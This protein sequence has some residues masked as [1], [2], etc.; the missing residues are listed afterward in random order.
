MTS[1][2]R[3]VRRATAAFIAIACAVGLVVALGT[4]WIA[5]VIVR[6]DVAADT[7]ETAVFVHRGLV[8]ALTSEPGRPA[9]EHFPDV[10]LPQVEAGTLLRVK[11][12]ERVA[13]DLLRLVYSDLPELIGQ[14]KSLGDSRAEVFETGE[15]LV[16][17]VPDDDAHRTE[18]TPDAEL[19]E[20]FTAFSSPERDYLLESY[21][22]TATGEKVARL[23]S[24]LLPVVL[25]GTLLFAL[26]MLPLAATLARRL[27]RA[28]RE[29][30]QL[31]DRAARERESE[32]MR[33][34]QQLHDGVV[35]DLAGASLALSAIAA[36]PRPDQGRIEAVAGVLRR[37]VQALRGLLVDLVPA[38]LEWSLLETALQRLADEVGVP[39]EA[40][41]TGE[42]AGPEATALLYRAARELLQNV[43]HHAGAARVRI[44]ASC[45]DGVA[46][47][48]VSDDG[49]G[50]DAS[51][52]VAAGHVGLR[53][54]QHAARGAGGGVEVTSQPGAGT[55]VAVWVRAD[56]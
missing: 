28:E 30:T 48:T 53:V 39:A 50:F 32:R 27:A 10:L 23:R 55:D 46:R 13:P 18:F 44:M 43:A 6:A 52:P 20:V 19:T 17:P 21:F 15:S 31:I 47:L 2:A 54:V 3:L 35:Q 51:A 49:R 5:D 56:A 7:E 11:V 33:L 26:A 1:P 42:Q 34:G 4:A 16:L 37:D 24:H 45:D 8:V 22:V 40:V 9:Q 12:W 41:V 36:S 29:R 38:D 14:E 25:G